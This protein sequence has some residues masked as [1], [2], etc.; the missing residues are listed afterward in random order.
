MAISA[1]T[2][3][4]PEAGEECVLWCLAIRHAVLHGEFDLRRDLRRLTAD[5]A[6]VWAVRIDQ[7]EANPPMYFEMNG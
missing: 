4:D 1:L 3:V 7:A 2:H 5:R 6:A